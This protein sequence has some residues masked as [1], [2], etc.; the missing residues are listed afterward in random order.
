MADYDGNIIDAK[1]PGPHLPRYGKCWKACR[2]KIFH[3]SLLIPKNHSIFAPHFQKV[4]Y[5]N[6]ET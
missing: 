4:I 2:N 1:V 6:I 3:H 5:F